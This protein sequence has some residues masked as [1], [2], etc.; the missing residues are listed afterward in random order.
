MLSSSRNI[1]VRV[2]FISEGNYH[3]KIS[4]QAVNLRADLAWQVALDAD[5]YKFLDFTSFSRNFYDFILIILP[6]QLERYQIQNSIVASYRP[7]GE[8]IGV[9]QEG[10]SNYFQDY[11][12]KGQIIYY[13]TL[14]EADIVFAHNLQD[15]H[16]YSGILH[17]KEKVFQIPSLMIED[18]IS[19]LPS[20][21]RDNIILGGN[22]VSW[23]GGFDSYMVTSML[24]SKYSPQI[25]TPE[26]GRRAPDEDLIEN[27]QSLSYRSWREWIKT[28]NNFKYAIHLMP[29]AA[30]GTFAL[31]CA[32]L[33]IP[34]IGYSNIDTQRLC[35]SK[36]TIDGRHEIAEAGKLLN[37]LF[38][39]EKFYTD[40]SQTCKE[41][42]KQHFSEES[43]VDCMKKVFTFIQ[44]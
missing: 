43:F 20:V 28:L 24:D 41:N 44:N 17:T 33:G 36:L 13:N 3:G 32:Y 34:C 18:S 39:D 12:L 22:F 6:K 23:Y 16:Y 35:H 29:T 40:C 9:I 27:V 21:Q 8:Y 26:M 14:Q 30:A 37:R 25:Y 10:P 31:N 4:R 5:H 7:Y 38:S 1:G 19:D 11:T 42:Y 15:V 2:A